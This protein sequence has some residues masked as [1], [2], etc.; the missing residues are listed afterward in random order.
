MN[1]ERLQELGAV[2]GRFLG[3]HVRGH[4]TFEMASA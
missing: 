2:D 1:Q 4:Q 3:F